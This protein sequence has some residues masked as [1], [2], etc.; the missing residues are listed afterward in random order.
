MDLVEGLRALGLGEYEARVY[1]AL[2]RHPGS[3]GYEAAKHSGVPRAKVYEVLRALTGRGLAAVSREAGRTR[4]H[5][6]APDALLA[7]HLR[8]VQE[9]VRELGPALEAWAKTPEREAVM[10]FR[11]RAAILE[12]ARD[13]A[14]SARSQLLASGWHGELAALEP[15]LKE[16]E[17][18]GV[19]VYILLYGDG[20]LAL[21]RVFRHPPP[22]AERRLAPAPWLIVVADH[23]EALV[24][25]GEGEDAVGL[26]SA[27]P[28]LSMVAAEYV[29]HDIMLLET[30]R[31]VG[32][33]GEL[34]RLTRALGPLQAMWFGEG[35]RTHG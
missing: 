7:R 22:D 19:A 33:R 24:A 4:Y 11:S 29:K 10:V 23:R 32:E 28:V 27:H 26:Y 20:A 9:L 16:A 17:A 14:V 13:L 15:A 6:L 35:E 18:R 5:A 25:Q 21:R 3:T 1:L 2:L 12:R 30:W 31:L 34:E 8:N